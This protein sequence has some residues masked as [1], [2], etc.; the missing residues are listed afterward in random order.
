MNYQTVRLVSTF[1]SG[2]CVSSFGSSPKV[3]TAAVSS[4]GSRL[5]GEIAAVSS[6]GLTQKWKLRTQFQFQAVFT[7]GPAQPARNSS[8]PGSSPKVET[9]VVSSFGSSTKVE[10]A[11]VSSFGS[12]PKVETVAVSSFGSRPKGEIAAVSSFGL[13]QKWKLRT[14]FQFQAVSTFGPAQPARN[15]AE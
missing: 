12:S 2:S 14:R 3:E 1:G 15:E 11:V 7:F 8:F 9:A 5:K 6:F 13:T 10:T 4:F